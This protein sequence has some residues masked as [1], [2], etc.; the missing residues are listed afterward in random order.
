MLVAFRYKLR[1][2]S[3]MQDQKRNF[4]L[5]TFGAEKQQVDIHSATTTL[6]TSCDMWGQGGSYI[7][8]SYQRL[9]YLTLDCQQAYSGQ[10][11]HIPEFIDE[12]SLPGQ[13][14]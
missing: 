5:Q 4:I 6:L 14:G 3:P 11:E 12:D 1:A 8:A 7:S 9:N 13:G 2:G 10:E